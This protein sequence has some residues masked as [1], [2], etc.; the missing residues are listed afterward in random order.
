MM[1]LLLLSSGFQ[2]MSRALFVL[3]KLWI[4]MKLFFFIMLVNPKEWKDLPFSIQHTDEDLF[5]KV[6]KKHMFWHVYHY[7][8]GH[9]FPIAIKIWIYEIWDWLDRGVWCLG[10]T[11]ARNTAY[12]WIVMSE[13]LDMLLLGLLFHCWLSGN[14]WSVLQVEVTNDDCLGQGTDETEADVGT[15]TH[16][17][18]VANGGHPL[19][20]NSSLPQPLSM[21]QVWE[22]NPSD[23]TDSE[24]KHESDVNQLEEQPPAVTHQMHTQVRSSSIFF[25]SIACVVH[26]C[27]M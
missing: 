17:T 12:W 24:K 3:Q 8:Q 2:V 14:L 13:P 7:Q 16:I 27:K 6:F 20:H 19:S 25:F 10:V 15:I 18:S 11:K 9:C 22:Y 26:M 5:Q 21:S 4:K 1:L 23:D